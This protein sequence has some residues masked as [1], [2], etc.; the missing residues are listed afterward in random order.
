M[1]SN[2]TSVRIC[3]HIDSYIAEPYWPARNV[4][5][6]LGKGIH[7]KYGEAKKKLALQ[8][9]MQKMGITEEE[10]AKIL[11][12][13]K[14]EF[15][16][17]SLGEIIIPRHQMAGM[18]VQ[19]VNTTP[20]QIRGDFSADSFRSIVK[21]SDFT[22]G[23]VKEDGV[24]E[25][26]VKGDQ[27]NQRRFQANKFIENFDSVGEMSL[28]SDID[29]EDLLRLISYGIQMTGLGGSRKMAFGR[30]ELLEP[31]TKHPF[32]FKSLKNT[33]SKPKMVEEEI[34]PDTLDSLE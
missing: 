20:K 29:I 1:S 25:R 21:I 16:C 10:Y 31:K 17:N 3:L 6:D 8:A 27:T 4:L 12:K 34:D 15:Y 19:T 2:Y 28:R 9:N 32:D 22:T 30:G 26:Y 7:P 33:P 11:A 18:L 23:K 24:Y 5:I 14:E 13:C